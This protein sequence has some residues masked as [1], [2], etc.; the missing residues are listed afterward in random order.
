MTECAVP[1]VANAAR[2]AEPVAELVRGLRI[3]AADACGELPLGIAD[4]TAETRYQRALQGEVIRAGDVA[5]IERMIGLLSHPD[6]GLR[7][8]EHLRLAPLA[9][10]AERRL[11]HRRRSADTH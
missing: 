3:D 5:G 1:G 7:R 6:H 8:R 4:R 2:N 11:L 10:D 9:I